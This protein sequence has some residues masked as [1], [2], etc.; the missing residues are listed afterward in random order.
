MKPKKKKKSDFPIQDAINELMK[1]WDDRMKGKDTVDLTTGK[2][3]RGSRRGSRR[4][5]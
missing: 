4:R 2:I 5:S 3:T 1:E